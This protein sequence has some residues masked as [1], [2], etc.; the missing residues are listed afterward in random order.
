MKKKIVI[1]SISIVLLLGLVL[2]CFNTSQAKTNNKKELKETS[3][4]LDEIYE[5][6]STGAYYKSDDTYSEEWIEFN[7]VLT[8]F[9]DYFNKDTK[10]MIYNKSIK[11]FE[12]D[13]ELENI[14]TVMITY[15]EYM[16][17]ITS[18][19]S[20]ANYDIK[21]GE[22]WLNDKKREEYKGLMIDIA[23][24]EVLSSCDVINKC[25]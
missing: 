4:N 20:S 11:P 12:N 9:Y 7:Y 14:G 8:H 21:V 13:E 3:H 1:I 5:L 23:A 22:N 2:L 18:D 25:I 24:R 15:D 19:K 10:F 16:K 17:I 6:I